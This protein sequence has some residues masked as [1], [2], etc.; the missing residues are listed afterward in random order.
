MAKSDAKLILDLCAG[1]GAWSQPYLDM[2]YDVIRVTLPELDVRTFEPPENVHG[3]LAA[4]PC[5]EFSLSKTTSPRDFRKGLEIVDACLRIV[6]ICQLREQ[7]L[8]WWA[9]ENPRGFLRQFLGTPSFTVHHWWFGDEFDKPTD[10]WGYFKYPKRLYTEPPILLRRIQGWPNWDGKARERRA[11]TP[12]CFAK[13]F[14]KA[15]P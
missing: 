4:P 2:G 6:R 12:P 13:A 7:R 1:T 10:L 5:T 3:I 11:I 9:L 15:N 8:A 14:F